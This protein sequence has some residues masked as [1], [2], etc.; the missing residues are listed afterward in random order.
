[1]EYKPLLPLSLTSQTWLPA[2]SI[3]VKHMAT[4]GRLRWNPIYKEDIDTRVLSPNFSKLTSIIDPLAY[5]DTEFGQRLNIPKY[6]IN[7]S[8]DDFFVP[9]GTL[10][11]ADK[12]PGETTIR[13][14]PNSDHRGIS[15]F[16]VQSLSTF[17]NR[18]QANKLLPRIVSNVSAQT[19][20]VKF[21]EVPRSVRQW[22]AHNPVSRDFRYACG[23]RYIERSLGPSL[24]TSIT[25]GAPKTGW[26]ATFIE[27][28]FDDRYVA[29]SQV[30]ITPDIYIRPWLCN[31][32]SMQNNSWSRSGS[33][34]IPINSRS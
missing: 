22:T 20:N 18:I 11:Y 31:G 12:L 5:L 23:I 4:T 25:L 19:L 21:S 1:M 17:V 29:T 13:V 9:D 14:A 24:K 30:Y 6:I 33:L 10:H 3:S 8:G 32:H 28:V 2:C 15:N 34:A 7:A 27:A 26:D 16:A